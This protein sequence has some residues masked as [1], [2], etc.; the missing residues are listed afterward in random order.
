MPKKFRPNWKKARQVEFPKLKPSKSVIKRLKA[1]G[2][3]PDSA[4]HSPGPWK[5][6][7][8]HD[9]FLENGR[10]TIVVEMAENKH[11]QTLPVA[12]VL[13]ESDALLI[14]AAPDL[15]AALK[16]VVAEYEDYSDGW[17]KGSVAF[18]ILKAAKAAIRKAEGRK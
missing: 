13:K 10:T 17:E 15:L 9:V 2:A 8:E 11:G 3:P 1:Q 12:Y 18:C 5:A 4:S 6:W 16:E 14:S 7:T